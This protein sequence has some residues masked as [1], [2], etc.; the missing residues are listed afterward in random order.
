MKNTNTKIE[1]I[2]RSA[3]VTAKVLNVIRIILTVGAVIALVS[4]IVCLCMQNRADAGSVL[5]DNGSVRILPPVTADMAAQAAVDGE[6]FDFINDLN[7]ENVMVWAG[8]NCIA[9]AVLIAAVTAVIVLIRRM[10]V[11][12]KDSDTPF[13]ES[14]QKRLKITGI[15]VTVIVF[16]KSIGMAAIVALSFWCLYCIFGYGVELQ[17]NEDETL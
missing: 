14:V 1:A 3:S 13:T 6:G 4:G 16:M 2:R 11:E 5:Y 9:A 12:L 7:I 10:F 17:K 8:L 15:L